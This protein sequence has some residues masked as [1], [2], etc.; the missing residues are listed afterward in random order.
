[1]TRIEPGVSKGPA[2]VRGQV[3][4]AGDVCRLQH[5]GRNR[6]YVED[7]SGPDGDWVHEDECARAFGQGLAG[8]GVEISGPVREGKANLMATRDGLLTVDADALEAFNLLPGVMAA[9]RHHGTVVRKGTH[10]GGT[11][12]IPLFLPRNDFAKAARILDH[13]PVLKVLPMRKARA[14]ILV[15][16]TEVFNGLIE[17]RF[18]PIVTGK[19]KALGSEVA[20]IVTVPDDRDAVRDAVRSL[21]DAGCDLIVALV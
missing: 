15:T 12:A 11:R 16:G 21:L 5:M 8:E 13:G 3:L 4:S 1:M 9:T 2:F 14:G 6:V 20:G 17:D 10:L 18:G 7:G 19:L